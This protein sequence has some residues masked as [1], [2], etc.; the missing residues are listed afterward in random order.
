VNVRETNERRQAKVQAG[1]VSVDNLRE[2]LWMMIFGDEAEEVQLTAESV[3]LPQELTP[4]ITVQE[5]GN[6]VF[7]LGASW[8][9]GQTRLVWRWI[10]TGQTRFDSELTWPGSDDAAEDHAATLLNVAEQSFVEVC[11]RRSLPSSTSIRARQPVNRVDAPGESIDKWLETAVA[12]WNA[13]P[14]C[15]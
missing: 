6:D 10:P 9:S 4:E 7:G 15:H 11:P 2:A 8:N 1:A 3:P 13:I 14:V 12:Q 5:S